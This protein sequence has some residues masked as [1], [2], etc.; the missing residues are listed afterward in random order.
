MEADKVQMD[1]TGDNEESQR[2]QAQIKKWDRKK[3]KIVTI[4]NVCTRYC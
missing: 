4:N 2:L 1:L 3:K